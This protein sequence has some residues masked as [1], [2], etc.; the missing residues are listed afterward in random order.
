MHIGKRIKQLVQE[1]KMTVSDFAR[2]IPCSRANVY[3]IFRKE[4]ID[5]GLLQQIGQI[6]G[7]DFFKDLSKCRQFGDM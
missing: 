4:T 6:L 1:R 2:A 3:K 7:Y 5:T